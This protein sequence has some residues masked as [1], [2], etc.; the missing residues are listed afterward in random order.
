M[1]RAAAKQV[2]WPMEAGNMAASSRKGSGKR[3][4]YWLRAILLLSGL[5]LSLPACGG[6]ENT[7][8]AEE[9]LALAAAGLSGMDRYGFTVRTE[10]LLDDEHKYE[11][12]AY[13]GEVV[14]HNSLKVW[15]QGGLKQL[16]AVGSE[17]ARVR[18]PAG[19]LARIEKLEKSVE[20]VPEGTDGTKVRLRIRLAPEAARQEIAAAMRDAFEQVAGEAIS[21]SADAVDEKRLDDPK[22]QRAIEQEITQ[23][24]TRLEMMLAAL[25]AESELLI[26]V[27]RSRLLPLRM[28]EHTLMRYG[29]EQGTRSENRMTFVTFE[30]FD[31]RP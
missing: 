7:H 8:T 27:E 4:A 15:P 26:D 13:E 31:G 23:S 17:D 24:R 12:E 19:W 20:Y 28:E 29:L 16:D 1:G 2:P 25:E 18:N 6:V 30:G 3:A 11:T 21:T 5:L 9:T 14:G 22:L 10:L